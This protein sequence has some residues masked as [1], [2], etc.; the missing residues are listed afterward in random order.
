[1]AVFFTWKV[2]NT[3]PRAEKIK[4]E[5]RDRMIL[6]FMRNPSLDP[7]HIALQGKE[8]VI[9][10]KAASIKASAV[11]HGFYVHHY[12]ESGTSMAIKALSDRAIL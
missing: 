3:A 10:Y 1:V 4:R 8:A 11:I 7:K 5:T 9:S 6:R 12:H 2:A